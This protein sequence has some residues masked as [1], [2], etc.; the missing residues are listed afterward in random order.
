MEAQVKLRFIAA[1]TTA[2]ALTCGEADLHMPV[3]P[4]PAS[5]RRSRSTSRARYGS[6]HH[7]GAENDGRR[8]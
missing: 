5:P 4:S 1:C 8:T 3:G 2:L 6:L 7:H